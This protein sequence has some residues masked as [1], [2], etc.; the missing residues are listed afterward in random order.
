MIYPLD[1]FFTLSLS[2]LTKDIWIMH[3]NCTNCKST[4]IQYSF[5]SPS[6]Q[7]TGQVVKFHHSDLNIDAEGTYIKDSVRILNETDI[8]YPVAV[9]SKFVDVYGL[10]LDGIL[11]LGNDNTSIIYKLYEDKQLDQPIYSLSYLNDPLLILGTPDFLSL[12]LVV[13]SQQ[14]VAFNKPLEITKFG[15]RDKIVEKP[16][17][18]ELSSISSYITGPAD[19]LESIFKILVE[20]GC[21]YEEELL[22]CECENDEYPT[23]NFTLQQQEFFLTSH[24]YLIQ[25]IHT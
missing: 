7:E 12:S 9:A 25:V 1:S 19:I 11:G 5:S 22:M 10:A 23:F 13:E 8:V 3:P 17:A 14:T 16:T 6:K 24:E 20:E 4:F 21:H 18:L 2:V 15:F